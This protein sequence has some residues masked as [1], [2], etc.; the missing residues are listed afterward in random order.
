MGSITIQLFSYRLTLTEAVEMFGMTP[1]VLI[2]SALVL[3]VVGISL[4]VFLGMWTYNDAKER[5]DNP[6]LWT[7]IVLFVP[8]P[9]GLIIYLLAGRD[10]SRD[11]AGSNPNRYL[12]PFIIS[13][14]FFVIN[15]SVVIGSAIYLII[16]LAENGMLN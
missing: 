5:T 8:M 13:A 1:L 14:V 12:R 7:L 11:R 6:V 2:I 10:T 15:L 9:I 4:A 3:A 16:Q